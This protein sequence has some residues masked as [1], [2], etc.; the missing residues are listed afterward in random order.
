LKIVPILFAGALGMA[1]AACATGPEFHPLKGG[2]GYSDTQ[3][4]MN[5]FSVSFA[6]DSSTARDKVDQYLLYRAAQLTLANGYDYFTV[7]DKQTDRSTEYQSYGFG[8][9]WVGPGWYR[10]GW[11]SSWWGI[12]PV[13]DDLSTVPSNRFNAT[14][15][16]TMHKGVAPPGKAS[17]YDAQQLVTR[18][19]PTIAT[20]G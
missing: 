20:A 13:F 15:T 6:G 3:L 5:R 2:V 14:A 18:L 19:G 12:D 11:R 16:I 9:R 7:M 8:S 10:P 1:S 4:Q 17:A